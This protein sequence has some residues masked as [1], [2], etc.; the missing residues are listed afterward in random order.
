M[1]RQRSETR[2]ERQPQVFVSYARQDAEKVLEIVGLLEPQGVTVWRDCDRILGGQ[3]Y[4]EQIV[5][6]IAHSRVVM[7]MCSPHAFHSDEVHREVLL[8]WE[9]YHRRYIPVW[10]SPEVEIPQRFRYCLAGCQWIDA[11]SELPERWLPQL[12]KAFNALGV[13]DRTGLRFRPGDR[14]LRGAN[15]ELVQLLGKG[16]FGEVWKAHNPDLPDVPPVALKFCLDLDERSNDLLQHEAQ[17]VLEAQRCIE[18][19]G[20]VPLFH[21]HLN[22]EPPCLEYPYIEGGTLV[23]LLD[24]YRES[25]SLITPVRVQRIIQRLAQI[26]GAAHRATPRLVHRD[27]KPSNIVA[28]RRADGEVVL[29]VMDFGIGAIAAHPVLDRSRSSMLLEGNLSSLLA[30]AHSPLYASPQQMRG[31]KPD[32]RD[33]VYALGVIWYQL[34]IGDQTLPAPTGQMWI[35]RLRRSGMRKADIDLLSSCIES[36]PAYRPDD[37]GVLAE[38]LQASLSLVTG[39]ERVAREEVTSPVGLEPA[40]IASSWLPSR[41]DDD[42]DALVTSPRRPVLVRRTGIVLKPNNSRVLIRPFELTSESRVER[43]IARVMSL[44]E[45]EVDALVDDL[46]RKFYNRHQKTRHFFLNR[47]EQVRR[48]LLTDQQLSENRRMLIGAS[49]TQEYA[50]ESAA[51]SNPSMVWHPDQSGLEP[52]S[53]RFIVSLRATGE[54]HISSIAFR[55]G[56]VDAECRV[57]MDE[58][59]RFVTAPEL[60]LNKL[61]DKK[62]FHRELMELGIDGPNTGQLLGM[63]GDQFTFDELEHTIR[64]ALH[65]SRPRQHELEPITQGM[66][67]LAKANYEIGYSP[68]QHLSERIIFPSSPT[69]ANG[70]EDARFVRFVEDEGPVRYYATYTAFDGK[71][72]LPQILETDDFLRFQISTLNGPEVR[73]EGFALFPRKVRGLYAML[74]RQDGENIYLMYSDM[75][76]FWYAKELI[77]K[78]QYAWEYIQIGNCGSPIETEAGWLVLTHGVSPMRNYA[79]GAMLL[80]LDDPSRVIGR[81]EVPF[82]EPDANEREGYVPNAVYSCGGLV[83]ERQLI[84]PYSMSDY[85][86]SFA[87]LSLDEVLEAMV[88]Y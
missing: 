48:Y 38:R 19:D 4:G 43:I 52:G 5:H 36:D 12:L 80:D 18:S 50:L 32:P 82:L 60:V 65:Q 30:G 53:R 8:T 57:R 6:A 61:Y 3:Y 10:L 37:A 70:I 64:R 42:R 49:F 21:A 22:N 67:S 1:A 17:I 29:R 81:L 68:E 26:V 79:L 40:R 13:D 31:E 39:S 85:A 16:G 54:G 55:S 73:N 74:S 15:W 83:H 88:R 75:L 28:E 76:H 69:E 86:S 7:L 62:L 78:P 2:A 46:M 24:E 27:L 87:T 47:F 44:A 35:E 66:L 45:P 51:L 59:T 9:H 84:I 77:A 71:V 23:R 58:P 41:I 20:I 63:L 56:T 72:I 34:L 11:H 14:P 25:P 33:D